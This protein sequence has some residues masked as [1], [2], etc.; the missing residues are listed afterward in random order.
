[1]GISQNRFLKNENYVSHC[2]NEVQE[3]KKHL[4]F[5]YEWIVT[6]FHFV[7]SIKAK[8]CGFSFYHQE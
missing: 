1:M 5:Y 2:F 8:L 7:Y 6:K 3:T 4:A